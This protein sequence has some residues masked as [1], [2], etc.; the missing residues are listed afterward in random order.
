MILNLVLLQVRL[1]LVIEAKNVNYTM[2]FNYFDMM[3]ITQDKKKFSHIFH[4]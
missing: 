1:R 4:H 2:N 3:N